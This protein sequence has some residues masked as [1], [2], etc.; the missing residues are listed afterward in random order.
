AAACRFLF[1]ILSVSFSKTKMTSDRSF[2]QC[3]VSREH[4]RLSNSV[5]LFVSAFVVFDGSLALLPARDT[6]AYSF[7]SQR[8]SEPVSVIATI[9]QQP[10]SPLQIS[11]G[12][13]ENTE[14]TW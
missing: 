3:P 9:R 13:A 12:C 2:R 7:I 6:R 5:T 10:V 1:A 14:P 4:L 11:A 8:L